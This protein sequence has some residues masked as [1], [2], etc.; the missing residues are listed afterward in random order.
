MDI[1]WSNTPLDAY[2]GRLQEDAESE[3][4]VYVQHPLG[5]GE[6]QSVVQS[7]AKSIAQAY[8]ELL[9]VEYDEETKEYR[10]DVPYLREITSDKTFDEG[11]DTDSIPFDGDVEV[12]I[13]RDGSRVYE[14]LDSFTLDDLPTILNTL[15]VLQVEQ[16]QREQVKAERKAEERKRVN[17][18]RARERRKL[19]ALGE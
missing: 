12:P 14:R 15:A 11:K 7:L 6:A 19:K 4:W 5:E 13:I 18:V 1:N 8:T 3:C 16:R 17:R 9:P 10:D 2:R